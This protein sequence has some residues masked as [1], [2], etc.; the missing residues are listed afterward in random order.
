MQ[1]NRDTI[2]IMLALHALLKGK[3][4]KASKEAREKLK[5]RL[6]KAGEWYSDEINP[7]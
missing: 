4:D 1:D 2:A 5:A 7:W 3:R 6:E